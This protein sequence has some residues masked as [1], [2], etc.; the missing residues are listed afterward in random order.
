[1]SGQL[2]QLR[3]EIERLDRDLI[4]LI[5]RRVA[6]AKQVGVAK[7]AAGIPTLDHTREAAVIRRAVAIAREQGLTID[8]E[9]RQIFWQLI[10]LSR[11][12]Q[13]DDA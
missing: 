8:E 5:A 10:G 7:R 2:S 4:Q 13:A 3:N 6:L 11:R 12:A 9:V 1:M